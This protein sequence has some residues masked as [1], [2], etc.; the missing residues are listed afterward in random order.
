MNNK[1]SNQKVFL[2]GITPSSSKGLHLG[3]FLGAVQPHVELQSQ[4]KCYYFIADYHALNTVFDAEEFANNVYETYLDYLALGIDLDKT[5]FFVES[6]VTSIF[7]LA[8]ILKNVVSLSQMKKMHAYKDKLQDPDAEIENINMGLFNYPILM[9]ADILILE[10]DVVPVGEDQSQHVEVAR[11]IAQRFNHRYGGDS[12]GG[13]LNVPELYIKKEV[14]R[15]PGTDGERK[16]SKSLGNDLT[17]F[18]DEAD[19]K[20]QVMGIT[21]DPNRIKKD[22]PGD[23]DKNVIFKYMELMNYDEAKRAEY[24]ERYKAGSVGDVE[25]KKEFLTFF[26]AYFAEARAKR[27][28]LA[29]DKD[30]I[31]S[32]M[33]EQAADANQKAEKTI[34]KIRKAIGAIY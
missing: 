22:D 27:A 2:S 24:I 15:V 4:G 9:A 26:L 19:I 25:I 14:A 6:H 7:E 32:L 29:Q 11:D 20:Q 13:V 12:E 5:T 30:A 21:T 33:R 1:S 16:M 34:S 3:N 10:P 8:E 28:E 17:I 23:P 31:L 18:A